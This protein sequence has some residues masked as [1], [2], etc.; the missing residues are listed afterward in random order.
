[1]F[2]PRARFEFTIRRKHAHCTV[3]VRDSIHHKRINIHEMDKSP[4]GRGT[5]IQRL[6]VG[7]GLRRSEDDRSLTPAAGE[8]ADRRR[9][10]PQALGL[11]LLVKVEVEEQRLA[12]SPR[13]NVSTGYLV[14][15]H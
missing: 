4:R 13:M 11:S 9:S 14:K 15:W 6:P 12:S 3:Y 10:G 2:P 1:M 8:E 5:E 7:S